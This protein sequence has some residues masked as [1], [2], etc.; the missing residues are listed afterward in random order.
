MKPFMVPA[1]G[2][3]GIIV[4]HLESDDGPRL[5]VTVLGTSIKAY[6]NPNDLEL[7]EERPG[8]EIKTLKKVFTTT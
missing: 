6:C 1:P 4:S 2:K 8:L 3:I 5:G 7:V